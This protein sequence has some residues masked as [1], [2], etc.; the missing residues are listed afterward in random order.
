[1]SLH[2]YHDAG[3]ENFGIIEQLTDAVYGQYSVKL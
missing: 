1:M 2:D 3:D